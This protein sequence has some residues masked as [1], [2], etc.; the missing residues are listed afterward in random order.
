MC[1]ICGICI[2]AGGAPVSSELLDAMTSALEHRGRDGK[3]C[4]MDHA[5]GLGHR[6]LSI[7]DLETGD[8]PMYNED[9][10]IVIVFNEEIYNYKELRSDLLQ[11][12]YAGWIVVLWA[13]DVGT[14]RI[15]RHGV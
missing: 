10:T 8:Q 5:I 13:V 9:R 15:G 12:F 6:R 4:H 1:G 7:I 14:H 11:R 3:G 2:E